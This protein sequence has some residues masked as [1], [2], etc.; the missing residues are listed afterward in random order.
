MSVGR[1]P[2]WSR[3]AAVTLGLVLGGVMSVAW[4]QASSR[5][6]PAPAAKAPPVVAALPAGD[7]EAGRSKA[8]SERCAECHGLEGQGDGHGGPA[9][10]RFAKLAGQRVDYLLKQMR[11]YRSGTRKHDVMKLMMQPLEEADLRDLAAYYASRPA[12]KK[13]SHG[14]AA[15]GRALYEQGDIARGV[16]PCASCHGPRAE[17][18]ATGPLLAGQE[19]HY[20]EQQLKDWRSGWRRNGAD[21][22]MNA[23]T[24]ALTDAEVLALTAFLGAQGR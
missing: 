19:P 15:K 22:T 12:M 2:R 24:K 18:T 4:G 3:A 20:L 13:E 16:L 21:A 1:L 9:N 5:A 6:R 7:I 11:D 10:T 8:D 23:V 17:G 14:E